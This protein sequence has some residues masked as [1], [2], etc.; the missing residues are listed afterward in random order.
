MCIAWGRRRERFG[1]RY[2][3]NGIL[4]S[5]A[6]APGQPCI[7][8]GPRIDGEKFSV[9]VFSPFGNQLIE[10]VVGYV[11]NAEVIGLECNGKYWGRTR[12]TQ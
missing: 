12:P 9:H 8:K 11:T 10:D 4:L 3:V 7:V 2:T 5:L 1:E 6:G